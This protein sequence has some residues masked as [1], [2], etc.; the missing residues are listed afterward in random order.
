MTLHEFLVANGLTEEWV[1]AEVPAHPVTV[2]N[3]RRHIKT[4]SNP[5]IRRIA[6]ITNGQVAPA[7]W[8]GPAP[9]V[10]HGADRI[11]RQIATGTQVEK[12]A[13]APRRRASPKGEKPVVRRRRAVRPAEPSQADAVP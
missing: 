4:P 7:D 2:H 5:K 6:E 13:R 1:V 9:D 8:F 3:W 12:K 11:T 10:P